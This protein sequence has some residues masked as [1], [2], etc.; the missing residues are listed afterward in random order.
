MKQ[1]F[2]HRME[3]Q[4][5]NNLDSTGY[6]QADMKR[7]APYPQRF[8]TTEDEMHSWNQ[9]YLPPRDERTMYSRRSESE[10]SDDRRAMR[11]NSNTLQYS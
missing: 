5:R 1:G 11:V 2:I 7:A 4:S 8:S 6:Y 3:Q 10:S 9:D